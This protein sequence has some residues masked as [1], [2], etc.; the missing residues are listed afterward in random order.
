MGENE[1]KIF[2]ICGFDFGLSDFG[3][4]SGDLLAMSHILLPSVLY[5]AP[6]AYIEQTRN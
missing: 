4:S 6:A 1:W 3:V 5:L 2:A